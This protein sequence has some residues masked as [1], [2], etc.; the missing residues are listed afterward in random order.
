MD[1]GPFEM[2]PTGPPDRAPSSADVAHNKPSVD[3]HTVPRQALP[4][5]V[6]P[7]ATRPESVAVIPVMIA[8]LW[9]PVERA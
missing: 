6:T 5:I 4:S 8:A 3:V 7:I 2:G 9:A 1:I